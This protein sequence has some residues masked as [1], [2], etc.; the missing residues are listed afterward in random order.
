LKALR[1]PALAVAL[2]VNACGGTQPAGDAA[3]APRSPTEKPG[4][5]L[6]TALAR[7]SEGLTPRKLRAEG[8]QARVLASAEP[9]VS[10]EGGMRQVT[11]PIGAEIDVECLVYD[12]DPDPGSTLVGIVNR[13]R[14]GAELEQVRPSST[15]VVREAPVTP[16]SV[17][18]GTKSDQGMSR[19]QLKLAFHGRLGGSSLCWHDRL[20]YEKTFS[21]VARSFFETL[22]LGGPELD[23]VHVEVMAGEVNEQPAGHDRNVSFVDG[24][25]RKLLTSSLHLF[26]PGPT[27]LAAQDLSSLVSVD[28]KDRVETGRWV[29]SQNGRL[30]LDVRLERVKTNR[31]RYEGTR[32]GKAVKGELTTKDALGLPSSF[33][34]QRE[35]RERLASAAAFTLSV[36][37]YRPS[38][39]PAAV[40]VL[41]LFRRAEDP[42]RAVRVKMLEVEALALVDERGRERRAELLVDG[43][44]V[45]I[46]RAYERGQ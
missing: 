9:R 25:V 24:G 32:A 29:E 1:R 44:R 19:G 18:Y 42:P 10:R 41:E 40:A 23:I 39:D 45:V 28:D 22:E 27:E 35:L 6:Q 3:A 38:K 16:L 21:Q 43:A 15:V 5:N 36:E 37:Q 7:E 20:G 13:L 8:L 46:E 34:T 12:R 33:W 26:R 2:L 14:A 31:Y 30:A 11:I 4:L 17:F